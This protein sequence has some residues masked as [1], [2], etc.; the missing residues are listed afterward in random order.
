MWN[1]HQLRMK[2][3]EGENED[4]TERRKERAKINLYEIPIG[5]TTARIEMK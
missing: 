3:T 2:R 4:T 1:E 5:I